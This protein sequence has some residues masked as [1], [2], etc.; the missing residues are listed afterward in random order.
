M[1]SY[2]LVLTIGEVAVALV[3]FSGVVAVLGH[4]SRRLLSGPVV[5][6]V[7]RHRRCGLA[8]HAGIGYRCK[9]QGK[10]HPLTCRCSGPLRESH[11]FQPQFVHALC[12]QLS[13]DV[14]RTSEW[15][16]KWAPFANSLGP[17]V[18][19]PLWCWPFSA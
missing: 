16:N 13:S 15:R 2:E 17:R 5:V 8:Y 14:G 12:R 11:T 10:R 9:E 6:T 7:C 18:L 19:Y 3:G 4:R 1:Q